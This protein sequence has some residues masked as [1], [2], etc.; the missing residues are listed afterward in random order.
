ME[1]SE[2]SSMGCCTC[3]DNENHDS[4]KNK[5]LEFYKTNSY[6]SR[7]ERYNLG[8]EK[9]KKSIGVLVGTGTIS[10]TSYSSKYPIL[11][12][13]LPEEAYEI[14]TGFASGKPII[15]LKMKICHTGKN[16]KIY[17]KQ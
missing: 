10:H 2:V 1:I 13:S 7:L 15:L 16:S 9:L 4:D 8:L 3:L 12:L 6:Y 17:F 5:C 14:L 11:N